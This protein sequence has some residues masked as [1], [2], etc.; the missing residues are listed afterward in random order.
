LPLTVVAFVPRPFI[1]KPS[2]FKLDVEPTINDI[3][4]ISKPNK[5]L[6]TRR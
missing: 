3:D 5:E 1:V 6:L 4:E 2:A